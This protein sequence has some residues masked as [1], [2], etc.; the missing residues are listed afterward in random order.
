MST[1]TLNPTLFNHTLYTRLLTL[2]FADLPPTAKNP[3]PALVS[4]WFGR[5][6]S[7]EAKRDFDA[8]CAATALPA[9]ESIA[10]DQFVLPEFQ[11][12]EDDRATNYGWMAGSFAGEYTPPAPSTAL[13][14]SSA[15]SRSSDDAGPTLSNEQSALALMLLLDQMPR[16]IFRAGQAPIYTHYDR[17]ARAVAYSVYGLGLD[18]SER[19]RASAPWRMWFYLP[20]M[21]SEGLGDHA[22]MATKL[23][24]LRADIDED[25]RRRQ[26]M[27]SG[28]GG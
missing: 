26:E 20:L 16:N 23:R 2:W 9:L 27:D 18:R 13:P 19:F 28:R 8:Q 17:I 21:H 11:S 4:R 12:A 7:A 24:G 5:G 3:T 14:T 1:F 22:V 10:A 25:V 15:N 6:A